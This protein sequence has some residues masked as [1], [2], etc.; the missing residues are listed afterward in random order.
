MRTSQMLAQA[1][2]STSSATTRPVSAA[3]HVQV[4][5][6]WTVYALVS[7]REFRIMEEDHAA[8]R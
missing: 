2:A 1:W 7:F 5:L 8:R 4:P 6:V 3:R